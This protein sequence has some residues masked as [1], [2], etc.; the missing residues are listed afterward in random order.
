MPSYETL[1]ALGL[2]QRKIELLLGKDEAYVDAWLAAIKPPPTNIKNPLGWMLAGI[3]SGDTPPDPVAIES[4][5]K[6][7]LIEKAENY[8]ANAG[9]LLDRESE[10]LDE[11]FGDHG[12]LRHYGDDVALKDRLAGI[13][14]DAR[15]KGERVEADFLARAERF[16]GQRAPAVK[17]EAA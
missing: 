16:R 3:K 6:R 4:G 12:L 10:V 1:A 11:L 5:R 7:A 15:P 9:Y 2:N 8:L 14:R 13:W 17:D